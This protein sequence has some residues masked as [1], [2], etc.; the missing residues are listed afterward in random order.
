M[1]KTIF[2]TFLFSAT[3]VLACKV[4]VATSTMYFTPSALKMCKKWYY[5]KKAKFTESTEYRSTQ[6]VCKE[7]K[8][9]VEMQGSGRYNPKEILTYTNEVKIM[10]GGEGAID[11]ATSIGRSGKCLITY[12]S[13]AADARYH[14]MGDIISMPSFKGKKL[15]LPDGSIFVHPGY[16]RVDDVGGAIKGASRFD[17]YTGNMDLKDANN[18]FGVNG[19]KD[20]RM[21]DKNFCAQRKSYEVIGRRQDKALAN[22]AIANAT[23]NISYNAILGIKSIHSNGQV[24]QPTLK[25][26]RNKVTGGGQN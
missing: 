6:K 25:V 19:P 2:I 11:C 14:K 1:K 23:K 26:K 24:T 16:F 3:Q 10:Q 4:P 13:V 12:V 15:T 22:T 17:F 7:F 20:A 18:A 5:G 9:E 21:E 8:A